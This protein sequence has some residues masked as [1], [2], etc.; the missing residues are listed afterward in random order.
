MTRFALLVCLLF[1]GKAVVVA[2][3][4][5]PYV[6]GDPEIVFSADEPDLETTGRNFNNSNDVPQI[7]PADR[8]ILAIYGPELQKE[9]EMRIGG[10]KPPISQNTLMWL[11][12]QRDA[13][14]LTL[15]FCE[16]DAI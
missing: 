2:D 7:I 4:Y 3:E 15:Q 11:Y 6:P 5:R 12:V 14:K 1:I 9:R 13:G 8:C 16:D 10:W